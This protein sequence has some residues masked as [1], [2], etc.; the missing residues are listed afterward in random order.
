MLDVS[1]AFN[2]DWHKC[3]PDKLKSYGISGQIFGF[4]SSCL[5]NRQLRMVL[6]GNPSLEYPVNGGVPQVSI[7][8]PTLFLI[9]INDL[10]DDII[11]NSAIYAD[12]TTLYTKCNQAS[13]LVATFRIGF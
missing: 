7:L 2:R 4:I 13:D 1:K 10:P 3:V 11:C 12:D 6:D 5:S 9:F 8:G